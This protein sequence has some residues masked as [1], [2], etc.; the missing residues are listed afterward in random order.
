MCF[1]GQWREA[2][3]KAADATIPEEVRRNLGRAFRVI[4]PARRIQL[5]LRLRLFPTMP[6]SGYQRRELT[7]V[8]NGAQGNEGVIILCK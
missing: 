6:G 7:C 8:F 4:P 1:R 5:C 2:T 3:R